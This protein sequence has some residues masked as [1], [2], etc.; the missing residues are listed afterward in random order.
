MKKPTTPVKTDPAESLYHRIYRAVRNIPKG[1]VTSYGAIARLVKAPTP[2]IVGYAMAALKPGTTVPWQRVVNHKGEIS[3]RKGGGG[4]IRQRR[5]L[6][7][8][9]IRFDRNGRIDLKTYGW[10]EAK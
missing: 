7:A 6:E 1:R 5:L 9:G 4:D 10:P 3:L 8:E 2:R